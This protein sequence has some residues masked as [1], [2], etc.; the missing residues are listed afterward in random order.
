[1]VGVIEIELLPR[2]DRA[3]APATD[4]LARRDN[5]GDRPALALMLRVVASRLRGRPGRR[6]QLLSRALTTRRPERLR[7]RDELRA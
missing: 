4:R 2:E 7:R 5:T 6:P 3:T 1:V